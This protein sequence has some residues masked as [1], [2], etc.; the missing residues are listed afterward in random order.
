MILA[1]SGHKHEI[2][3]GNQKLL[4]LI[5]LINIYSDTERGFSNVVQISVYYVIGVQV[6]FVEKVEVLSRG[7]DKGGGGAVDV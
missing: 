3:T 6:Q 5:I 4:F 7:C 1:L 2:C